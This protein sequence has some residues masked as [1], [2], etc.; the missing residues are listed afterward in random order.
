MRPRGSY[1]EVARALL[2]AADMG[3]GAVRDLAARAQ[4]G[5]Q[6]AAVNCSRLV[7]RGELVVL[8]PDERP[9]T[10]ARPDEAVND[11][12]AALDDLERSFWERQA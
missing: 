2:S 7:A 9:A 4:V 6:A 1:G 5:Y 12:A 10:L 8:D 11:T 3:P